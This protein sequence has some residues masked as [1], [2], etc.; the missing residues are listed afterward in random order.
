[1]A[2]EAQI[3]ECLDSMVR[4]CD[5][6][7]VSV[8]SVRTKLEQDLGLIAGRDYEKAPHT[9]CQLH[10]DTS[11]T[12]AWLRE[13]LMSVAIAAHAMN[14]AQ[15]AGETNAADEVHATDVAIE[16][17]SEGGAERDDESAAEQAAD[18]ACGHTP[19]EQDESEGVNKA[20]DTKEKARASKIVIKPVVPYGTVLWG[21]MPSFP[22]WPARVTRPA[23]VNKAVA[24]MFN[25]GEIFVRFFGSHD[26]AFCPKHTGDLFSNVYSNSNKNQLKEAVAEAEQEIKEPT[27]EEDGSDVLMSEDDDE[28]EEEGGEEEES[29]NDGASEQGEPRTA[30]PACDSSDEEAE[31]KVAKAQQ[32][33]PAKVHKKPAPKKWKNAAPEEVGQ[34][35]KE[36]SAPRKRKIAA[37]DSSEEEEEEEE[38]EHEEVDDKK[39]V[40]FGAVAKEDSSEDEEADAQVTQPTGRKRRKKG[41]KVDGGDEAQEKKKL[42]KAALKAER[43]AAGEPK[44]NMNAYMFFCNEVRSSIKEAN[45]SASVSEISKL[46]SEKWKSLSAEEKEPFLLMAGADKERFDSEMVTFRATHGETQK[47][48]MRKEAGKAPSKPRQPR[49]PGTAAGGESMKTVVSKLQASTEERKME[50]IRIAK[51]RRKLEKLNAERVRMKEAGEPEEQLQQI[52]VMEQKLNQ[53]CEAH[54]ARLAELKAAVKMLVSKVDELE[55]QQ[56]ERKRKRDVCFF[57]IST[58]EAKMQGKLEIPGDVA[59]KDQGKK[60]KAA[61]QPEL[62][63]NLGSSRSVQQDVSAAPSHEKRAKEETRKP[64]REPYDEVEGGR[65]AEE[66]QVAPP[67]K[68]PDVEGGEKK[69][70]RKLAADSDEEQPDADGVTDSATADD[71]TAV[72]EERLLA[73]ILQS[74]RQLEDALAAEGGVDDQAAARAL[75]DLEK[76][77]MTISLLAQS[78]VGKTLTKL[79]KSSSSLAGRA[80]ALYEKWKALASMAS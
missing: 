71:S 16:G 47:E 7:S 55:G 48:R 63:V 30:A 69:K 25:K 53:D 66:S 67:T 31:T 78:G 70:K 79:R 5:L 72:H 24:E 80:K 32:A 29:S 10:I 75:T 54:L 6:S 59:A 58:Y 12:Q 13:Q 68:K 42:G 64:V 35:P 51:C 19:E 52:D 73:E 56:L 38:D 61:Q 50:E 60:M 45:P 76:M 2:A 27:Y 26:F 28:E 46:S 3:M 9:P 14:N 17:A 34:S 1:M 57:K 15:P 11:C 4:S 22:M 8:K 49:A 20:P 23:K 37:A 77:N 65:H 41:S 33:K 44:K 36:A 21:K 43:E 18:G 40:D 62:P 39:D 74:K